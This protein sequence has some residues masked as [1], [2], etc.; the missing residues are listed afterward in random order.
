MHVV[1][2]ANEKYY[3][4]SKAKTLFVNNIKIKTCQ[5]LPL[6]IDDGF[7]KLFQNCR[8]FDELRA[9]SEHKEPLALSEKSLP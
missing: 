6:P 4:H 9:G 5:S 3:V 7:Y 1:L 8:P 2:F